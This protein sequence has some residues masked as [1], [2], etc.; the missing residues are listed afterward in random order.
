MNIK[1]ETYFKLLNNS[2]DNVNSI[3][4]LY[5][6]EAKDDWNFSLSNPPFKD[7]SFPSKRKDGK[8]LNVFSFCRMG[9][10]ELKAYLQ[11]KVNYI[12]YWMKNGK[13]KLFISKIKL[14]FILII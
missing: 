7:W 8:K 14:N 10:W 6:R 11:R 3:N 1:Y 13:E 2:F 5:L 4:F 9:K 12:D